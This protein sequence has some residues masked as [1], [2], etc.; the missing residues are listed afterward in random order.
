MNS[1][2]LFILNNTQLAI[3]AAANNVKPASGSDDLPY[4]L[5]V[6]GLIL[7][8][9][10]LV[11]VYNIA[12]FTKLLINIRNG[13]KT[14][15]RGKN[16]TEEEIDELNV[17]VAN[18]GFAYDKVQDIFYSKMDAWQREFG[19]C[20]LYDEACA[21]MGMIIDCEPIYFKFDGKRWLI[22]LWKG[23]YGMTT[24]GEIGVYYTNGPDINIPGIFNGTFYYCADDENLLNMSFTLIKNGKTIINRAEKHWWITGFALG[25][26]SDTS[27]LKMYANITLKNQEMRD[28]FA[29]GLKRAGYSGR[30]FSIN[31]NTV[32]ILFDKPHT[33]QPLMRIKELERITQA[34][35]K[36][37]CDKYKEITSGYKD[38]SEKLKAVREQSPQLYKSAIALGKPR[39]VFVQYEDIKKALKQ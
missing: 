18:A 14:L 21:I 5:I 26:F 28:S 2:F 25:E 33:P 9:L 8:L 15:L 27:E 31:H 34:K 13:I 20:R 35:N 1:L 32:N 23:Q 29:E 37:L 19:Y 39:N 11:L 3:A 38:I 10:T 30:E 36:L 17:L 12:G 4:Y 6:A 24:G 7:L 16:A 22:E